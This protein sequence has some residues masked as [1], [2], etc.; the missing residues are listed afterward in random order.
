M[1]YHF[2]IASFLLGSSIGIASANEVSLIANAPTEITYKIAHK[3]VAGSTEFGA[4][5]TVHVHG[6]VPIEIDLDGYALGGIVPIAINGHRIPTYV[7]QF[8]RENQCSMA[9]DGN[10]PTGSLTFTTSAHSFTCGT[11]GGIIR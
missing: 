1:K 5:Q 4:E 10:H 11:Q 7:T 9:T 6:S 2:I 8:D 3:N